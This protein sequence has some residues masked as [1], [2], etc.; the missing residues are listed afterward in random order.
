M[1][2]RTALVGLLKES[3]EWR[4]FFKRCCRTS[5]YRLASQGWQFRAGLDDEGQRFRFDE[6]ED[7]LLSLARELFPDTPA[8][9]WDTQWADKLCKDAMA[10][11]LSEQYAGLSEEERDALDL[12][13]QDAHEA[14]MVAAAEANDPAEFRGALKGWEQVGV[15]A[16]GGDRAGKGAA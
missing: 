2:V 11:R 16:I 1:S 10:A 9:Q 8:A 6:V 13:G 14:R 15:G 4:A 7:A 12:S 5:G 3:G